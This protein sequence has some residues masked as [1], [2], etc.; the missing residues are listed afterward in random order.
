MLSENSIKFLFAILIIIII[1]FVS[2]FTY[3]YKQWDNYLCPT[4][5]ITSFP[6][7]QPISSNAI[8]QANLQSVQA[9]LQTA[10]TNLLANPQYIATQAKLQANPQYIA[11]QSKFQS[12]PQYFAV[13]VPEK[14]QANQANLQSIADEVDEFQPQRTVTWGGITR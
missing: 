3:Y 12:N 9:N 11:S 10:Q 6:N 5:S 7:L 1:I 13:T 2:L 14:L 4:C 8:T